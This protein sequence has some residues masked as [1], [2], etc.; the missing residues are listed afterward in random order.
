MFKFQW[1]CRRCVSHGSVPTLKT[2]ITTQFCDIINCWKFLYWWPMDETPPGLKEYINY[3]LTAN[4]DLAG[5]SSHGDKLDH[6]YIKIYTSNRK[7]GEKPLQLIKN[8]YTNTKICFSGKQ[9]GKKDMQQPKFSVVWYVKYNTTVT[10]YPRTMAFL[11]KRHLQGFG[12]SY[13]Q[14]L[15]S[16]PTRSGYWNCFPDKTAGACQLSLCAYAPSQ[17]KISWKKE[18]LLQWSPFS[19]P[20]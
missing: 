2:L 11:T 12:F 6:F 3:R 4:R 16:W 5:L 9:V 20:S 13:L 8:I 15:L 17:L 14:N 18:K 1:T 10:S 7:S 19:Y